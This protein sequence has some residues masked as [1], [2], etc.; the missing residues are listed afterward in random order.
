MHL[1]HGTS[2]LST[3]GQ[4]G[5]VLLPWYS[6]NDDEEL[7]CFNVTNERFQSSNEWLQGCVFSD[8]SEKIEKKFAKKELKLRAFLGDCYCT[9]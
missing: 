5:L 3:P 9:G 1:R 7:C 8:R 4:F 6:K 2:L